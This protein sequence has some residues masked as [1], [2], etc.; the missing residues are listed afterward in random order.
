MSSSF[1]TDLSYRK[2]LK[3][4]WFGKM[5]N[6]IKYKEHGGLV[7]ARRKWEDICDKLKKNINCSNT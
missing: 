6:T 5:Y 1:F 7:K 2:K 4:Q 3:Q